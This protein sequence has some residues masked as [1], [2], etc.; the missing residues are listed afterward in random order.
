MSIVKI[1][2][3]TWQRKYQIKHVLNG[4]WMTNSKVLFPNIYKIY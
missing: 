3:K 2:S 4:M 1:K